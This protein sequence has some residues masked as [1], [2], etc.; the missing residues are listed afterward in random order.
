MRTRIIA[1][2]VAGLLAAQGCAAGHPTAP[3]RHPPTTGR[4]VVL[5]ARI[6]GWE[7]SAW[8]GHR[9]VLC[10]RGPRRRAAQKARRTRASSAT[11]ALGSGRMGPP[12][13]PAEPL[14]YPAPL[15]PQSREIILVGVVRGAVN[16][17]S[18]TMFGKTATAA[19]HPLPVTDGRQVGAYAVSPAATPSPTGWTSPISPPLSAATPLAKL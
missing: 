2:V 4:P 19:V 18:V 12:L 1:I 16:S 10:T 9:L 15:D 3:A 8:L 17:V 7:T 5:D 11:R 14:P 6:P 13:L